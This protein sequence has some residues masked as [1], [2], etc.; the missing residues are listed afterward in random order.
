[1]V[2]FAPV[3]M[4]SGDAARQAEQGSIYIDE[5]LTEEVLCGFRSAGARGFQQ[6]GALTGQRQ[7]KIHGTCHDQLIS[8]VRY[9]H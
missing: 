2:F 1:M 9:Q 8:T 4:P 6:Q 5:S 7:T 3:V